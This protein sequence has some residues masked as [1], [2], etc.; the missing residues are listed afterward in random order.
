M[1]EEEKKDEESEE[2][3]EA[4]SEEPKEPDIDAREE[5]STVLVIIVRNF[6]AYRAQ[7]VV[8]KWNQ[9]LRD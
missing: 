8:L 9:A 3:E 7:T 2:E 5:M 4:S 6:H 1:P